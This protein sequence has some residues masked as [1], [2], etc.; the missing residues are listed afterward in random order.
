MPRHTEAKAIVVQEGN[1]TF[2]ACNRT[3]QRHLLVDGFTI[4]KDARIRGY[5]GVC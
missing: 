4:M 5:R 3:C 2:L 1:N